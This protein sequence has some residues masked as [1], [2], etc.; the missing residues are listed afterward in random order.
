MKRIIKLIRR[1][2]NK[3]INSKYFLKRRHLKVL[4]NSNKIKTNKINN[5]SNNNN[6]INNNNNYINFNK[7]KF[8]IGN[9][10]NEINSIIPNDTTHLLLSTFF[11]LQ[12]NELKI[13]RSVISINFINDC[14]F[15]QK[16]CKK[17]FPT[18]NK[19]KI[20]KFGDYFNNNDEPIKSGDLPTSL[21][22]LD[23]GMY[24]QELEKG[25]IPRNIKKLSLGQSFNREIQPGDIPSRVVSLQFSE[26]FNQIIKPNTLPNSIT[27]L[28]FG[29]KFNQPLLPNSIPNNCKTLFFGVDFNQQIQ[30]DVIPQSVTKIVFNRSFSQ[31]ILPNS[32]KSNVK[33]IYFSNSL[34][35]SELENLPKT[36]KVYF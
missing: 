12:L 29:S 24:S 19:I 3:I 10:I 4:I 25:S 23:L 34:L 6:N 17:S 21:S 2:N 28:T 8:K 7:K 36:T 33:E 35:E 27:D 11:N 9:N 5:Y 20:L 1:K 14:F 26:D 15:N 30:L 18:I 22:E 16:V 31:K 32:I 13:P